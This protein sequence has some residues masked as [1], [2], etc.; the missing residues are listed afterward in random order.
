ME[1]WLM[2]YNNDGIYTDGI[3]EWLDHDLLNDGKWNDG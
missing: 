3:I 2:E 1:Y